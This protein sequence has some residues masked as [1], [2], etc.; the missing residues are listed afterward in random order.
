MTTYVTLTSSRRAGPFGPAAIAALL[1]V[2]VAAP[3]FAQEWVEYLNREDRFGVSFPSQPTV[4][5]IFYQGERGKPLPARVYSAQDGASRYSVTVVD[6]TTAS[7][8]DVPGSIAW[9]AWNFRKRGGQV[10]Q[11]TFANVD[12]IPGHE[13]HITNRDGSHTFAQIHLHKRRLYILEADI[14]PN[15]PTP[16]AVLFIQS[17]SILDEEGRRIRYELDADGNRTDKRVR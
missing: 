6:Y 9:E 13:L 3:A 1:V 4:K 7:I 5:E 17:L 8:N 10:T 15:A 2:S 14:P 12:R 16:G 11:D